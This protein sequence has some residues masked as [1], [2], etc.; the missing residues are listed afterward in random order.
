MCH[1]EVG[2]GDLRR[3]IGWLRGYPGLK[4]LAVNMGTGEGPQLLPH[5]G[6]RI[7]EVHA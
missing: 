3:Y 5:E 4:A 1:G 6:R 7:I 2:E